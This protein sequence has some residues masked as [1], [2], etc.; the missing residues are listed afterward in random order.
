VSVVVADVPIG[1]GVGRDA[2]ATSIVETAEQKPPIDADERSSG[3]SVRN[4]VGNNF[5][6]P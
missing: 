3:N 1:D 5:P 6:G 4:R 2:D